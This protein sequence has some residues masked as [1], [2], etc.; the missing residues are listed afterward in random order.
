M[1]V[2]PPY[3]TS[4][5]CKWASVAIAL[6]QQSRAHT[7]L[8]PEMC[9][10]PSGNQ[11]RFR[12]PVG[13]EKPHSAENNGFRPAYERKQPSSPMSQ[14]IREQASKRHPFNLFCFP[15]FGR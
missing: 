5:R 2:Y 10:Q 12:G 3:E 11:P 1:S 7:D 14:F 8:S 6:D 13:K 9:R 4:V 15:F